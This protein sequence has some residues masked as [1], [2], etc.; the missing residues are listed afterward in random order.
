MGGPV[1]EKMLGVRTTM[2]TIELRCEHTFSS[3][4]DSVIQNCYCA[5]MRGELRTYNCLAVRDSLHI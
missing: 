4:F 2:Q 5:V 1:P 3:H